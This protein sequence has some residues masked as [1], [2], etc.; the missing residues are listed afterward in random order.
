MA[1]DAAARVIRAIEMAFDDYTSE[2]ERASGFDVTELDARVRDYLVDVAGHVIID[3]LELTPV[4]G[5]M[6]AALVSEVEWD[7][8]MRHIEWGSFT[9]E[10][11]WGI[12]SLPGD[13]V[14]EVNPF[15]VSLR[16]LA[17]HTVELDDDESNPFTVA[18][19][20]LAA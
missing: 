16:E 5:T 6:D 7:V 11:R 12:L 4:A 14:D 2:L 9:D 1:S 19:R 13:L 8:H 15:E 18:A 3:H 17:A 20:E 10:H